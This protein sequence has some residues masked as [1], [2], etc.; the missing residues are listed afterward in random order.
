MELLLQKASVPGLEATMTFIKT[1]YT[2]S[3]IHIQERDIEK[4]S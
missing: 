3:T 1:S 2:I 4:Q